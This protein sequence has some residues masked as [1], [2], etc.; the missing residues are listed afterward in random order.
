MLANVL[1]LDIVKVASPLPVLVLLYLYVKELLEPDVF[2]SAMK[3][4]KSFIT[5][6]LVAPEESDPSSLSP[7][8]IL[9]SL[10]YELILAIMLLF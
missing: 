4:C 10:L 2:V 3:V 8:L 9:V 6:F 7:L 5:K 1:P